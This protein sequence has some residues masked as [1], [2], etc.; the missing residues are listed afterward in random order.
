[1]SRVK[2]FILI[3]SIPCFISISFANNLEEP[4]LEQQAD[5]GNAN[6]QYKLGIIYEQDSSNYNKSK[7][8]IDLY[9]KSA[10]QGNADAQYKI[11]ELYEKG[12]AI[13]KIAQDYFKAVEWYTKAANQG[14]ANAQYSLG[15]LYEQSHGV[16]QDYNKAIEWYT[17][18]ANQ[19][20]IIAQC[21][22]GELYEKINNESNQPDY[23]EVVKWYTKIANQ[24][25]KLDETSIYMIPNMYN[26]KLKSLLSS[27]KFKNSQNI[28]K[29]KEYLKQDCLNKSQNSCDL[30]K[31]LNN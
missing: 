9:K 20:L 21:K 31:Q 12:N 4:S 24:K 30:F 2:Y 1:M 14:N 11:G 8:A 23:F 18:A 22:L 27:Q 16:P 13:H 26:G 15:N 6:A 25:K 5:Q 19:D 10:N 7:Q 29:I 17:K 28:P 3:L